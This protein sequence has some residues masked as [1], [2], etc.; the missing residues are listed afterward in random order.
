MPEHRYLRL[1]EHMSLSG[2]IHRTPVP[3]PEQTLSKLSPAPYEFP[4]DL[5]FQELHDILQ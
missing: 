5:Q 1:S 2:H 3:V 4:Q